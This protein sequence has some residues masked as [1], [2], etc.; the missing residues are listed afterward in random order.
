[1]GVLGPRKLVF[2]ATAFAAPGL[3]LPDAPIS[4]LRAHTEVAHLLNSATGKLSMTT[5]L[6]AP[7]RDVSDLAGS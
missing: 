6:L 1:L 2:P 3:T 4:Q 5:A 7:E